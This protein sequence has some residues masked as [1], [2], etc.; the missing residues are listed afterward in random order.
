MY[1]GLLF[2]ALLISLLVACYFRKDRLQILAFGGVAITMGMDIIE[3]PV[4][5]HWSK[6]VRPVD[7]TGFNVPLGIAWIIFGCWII[8]T[9]MTKPKKPPGKGE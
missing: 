7:L 3:N 1:G 6:Y 8:W 4:L 5:Y 9:G 2:A